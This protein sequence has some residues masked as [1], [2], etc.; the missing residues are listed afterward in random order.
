M[1][2]RIKTASRPPITQPCCTER[3]SRAYAFIGVELMIA[4]EPDN[5]KDVANEVV[6]VRGRF[7]ARA[8]IAIRLSPEMSQNSAHLGP[9]LGP[10]ERDAR[11]GERHTWRGGKSGQQLVELGGCLR[12]FRLGRFALSKHHRLQVASVRRLIRPRRPAFELRAPAFLI[13]HDLHVVRAH[14]IKRG[15]YGIL[16]SRLLCAPE[17]IRQGGVGYLRHAD[18]ESAV[19]RRTDPLEGYDHHDENLLGGVRADPS[20][21]IRARGCV[22]RERIAEPAEPFAY[23]E[24]HMTHVE[25]RQLKVP[26]HG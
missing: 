25:P 7:C 21:A 5:V 22:C 20:R 1:R 23:I 9:V 10:M 26:C 15:A 2:G 16:R 13:E 24:R 3:L 4:V 12:D 8:R 17:Y 6:R 18:D 19:Y 14:A 11:P